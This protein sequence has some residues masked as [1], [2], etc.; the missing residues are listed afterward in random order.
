MCGRRRDFRV[1]V[2]DWRCAERGIVGVVGVLVVAVYIE[3]N[4]V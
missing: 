3:S 4:G 2:V 1:S